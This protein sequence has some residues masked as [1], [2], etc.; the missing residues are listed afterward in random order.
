MFEFR[1]STP[2]ITEKSVGVL[3][4][5]TPNTRLSF[6]TST[7]HALVVESAATNL[8]NCRQAVRKPAAICVAIQSEAH[9]EAPVA[10]A[11]EGAAAHPSA[12]SH[13]V[14]TCCMAED[15]IPCKTRNCANSSE[16]LFVPARALRLESAR[17]VQRLRQAVQ[18]VSAPS[19][20][21]ALSE[22]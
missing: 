20:P 14:A 4:Q 7:L 18:L 21:L 9:R 11:T 2:P 8:P 19:I 15:P 3:G 10:R 13:S 16:S 6:R 22:A 17:R 12:V 5:K 1:G